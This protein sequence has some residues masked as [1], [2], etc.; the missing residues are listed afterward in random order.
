M[1]IRPP[2]WLTGVGPD[3]DVAVATRCRLAR[4]L[5]GLAFPWRADEGDR[6]TAAERILDAARRAGGPLAAAN[7]LCGDHLTDKQAAQL[8]QW[9]Y[10]S[11]DWMAGGN[12]RWLLIAPD[13]H[14]SLL[15]NE[16]DHI[17]VQ[18]ILPGVQV[19]SAYVMAA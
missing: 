3:S 4:N 5:D 10:A 18:A 6:K 17:R 19:E 8:L 12:H 16:E 15:V 9:R 7:A 13:R 2:N 14:L 1:N 11:R